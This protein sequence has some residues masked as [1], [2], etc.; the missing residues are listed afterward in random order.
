MRT[1]LKVRIPAARGNQTLKD[2]TL[3]RT[4]EAFMKQ[5]NPE[6]AYFFADD[7]KRAALFV[8]DLPD[9]TDIPVMAETF[10][11]ALE[12]ETFVT[13]VMNADDL[14]AGVEKVM[15]QLG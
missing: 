6:A 7:G 14:R 11:M 9:A 10:F 8:F 5:F 12:A 2:G 15:K 1:M 4:F 3:P 13:P